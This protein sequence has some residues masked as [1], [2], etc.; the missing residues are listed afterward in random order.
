MYCCFREKA[1]ALLGVKLFL[2]LRLSQVPLV[3]GY[4]LLVIAYTCSNKFDFMLK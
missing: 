1:V 3:F 2:D 4:V